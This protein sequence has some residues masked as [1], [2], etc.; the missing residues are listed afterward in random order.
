MWAQSTEDEER[1]KALNFLR[2]FTSDLA[3]DFTLESNAIGK[4]KREEVGRLL[5]R[6]YFKQ[7][8]WQEALQNLWS[9]VR[10]L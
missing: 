10:E 4:D 7:G 3:N 5:A 9:L 1:N 2:G 8:Q 6:C